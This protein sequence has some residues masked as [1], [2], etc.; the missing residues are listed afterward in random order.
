M[1]EL[2]KLLCTDSKVESIKKIN[3]LFDKT[4]KSGSGFNLFDTKISDYILGGES[5]KGWALQGTYVSG[6]LYPDFYAKCLEEYE[7]SSNVKQWLQSNITRV[8]SLIDNN[9]VI[10]GF[11]STSWAVLPNNFSPNS[12]NWEMFLKFTTGTIGPAQ[13]LVNSSSLSYEQI[14][15]NIG[16]AGNL[17]VDFYSNNTSTKI[18]SIVGKT[19]LKTNTDYYCLLEYNSI[20]GYTLKLGT[21][22]ENLAM[23]GNST[24]TTAIASGYNLALGAN[25]TSNGV[26]Y[27]GAFTGSIDLN[28]SY[29]NIN[30]SRWWTGAD[31]VTKNPN[32]HLFY[33]ITAKQQIDDIYNSTGSAWFYGIDT[34]NERIF[35]PRDKYFAVKG[36]VSTVPVVG[37]GMALGITNNYG[38]NGVLASESGNYIGAWCSTNDNRNLPFSVTD[39]YNTNGFSGAIGVTT[40][41]TKSGIVA[42]TSKVVQPNTDK[43]LYICVGN[44]VVNDTEIDAGGLVAQMEQKANI[45]L[46]NILPSQS[47]KTQITSWIIP[48]YSAGIVP[49]SGFVCPSDGLIHILS[50]YSSGSIWVKVN[51]VQIYQYSSGGAWLNIDFQFNVSKG[52]VITFALPI[53]KYEFDVIH[54]YPLKGVN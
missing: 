31:T 52:D 16:S 2:E 36:S 49:S 10:N 32:G 30:G 29:I 39:A 46:D 18:A 23:E 54:F 27:D 48:D 41:P 40:D 24:V 6:A 34:E 33:P 35:L 20:N 15:L 3:A 21:N 14:S 22:K 13:A 44:T 42:D 1:A 47:F 37:N 26:Y 17:A 8:G 38:K 50:A 51:G 9:G 19:T 53:L 45:F 28:E 7:N 25:F 43:Y 12:S 5:A 4:E 11:N